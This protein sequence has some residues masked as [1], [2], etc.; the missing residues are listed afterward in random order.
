MGIICHSEILRR[1]TFTSLWNAW[2][3]SVL[4]ALPNNVDLSPKHTHEQPLST[5]SHHTYRVIVGE[6]S[7]LSH[8]TRPDLTFSIAALAPSL[9]ARLPVNF[10]WLNGFW[11]TSSELFISAWSFHVTAKSHRTV[12]ELPLKPTGVDVLLR[13]DQILDTFSPSTDL[14]YFGNQSFKQS[15]HFHQL[16]RN[17]WLSSLVSKTLRGFEDLFLKW[18]IENRTPKKSLFLQPPLRLTALPQYR[19]RQIRIPQN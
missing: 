5:A 7:C 19:S 18:I 4:T 9:H 12:C 2:M 13:D 3:Q 1:T 8:C 15:L 10:P 6:I 11:V 17:T 16:K 14:R